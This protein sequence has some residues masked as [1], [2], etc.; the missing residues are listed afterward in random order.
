MLEPLTGRW[1]C[2]LAFISL[3]KEY[4]CKDNDSKHNKSNCNN[5]NGNLRSKFVA[6]V[7]TTWRCHLWS[8]P[9]PQ[10]PVIT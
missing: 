2:L 7:L 9:T 10:A 3:Q 6:I 4:N 1:L 8:R 5:S